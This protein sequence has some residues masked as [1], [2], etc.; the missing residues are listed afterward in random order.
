[1]RSILLWAGAIFVFGCLCACSSKSHT[2]D[3]Y[4]EGDFV[5]VSPYVSGQITQLNV[6]R[7]D[8]VT[9]GQPLFGLQS[10][11]ELAQLQAAQAAKANAEANLQ[12]LQKG[13]RPSEL[14]EIEGQIKQAQAQVIYTQQQEQRYKALIADGSIAQATLDQAIQDADNAR[15]MLKQYQSALKTAQLPAR[16]DLI[17]AAQMTVNQT[18]AQLAQAQW[19]YQQAMV[20]APVSGQVMDIY[21]WVGEQAV[22]MQ[23]VLVLLPPDKIKTVFFV[24][25]P[26]LKQIHLGES[27][28]VTC[29]GCKSSASAV[30]R[31]ISPTAEYTPPVIYSRSSESKLVYRVE[32]YFDNN[33]T[34][35]HPGQ[36]VMITASTEG[37]DE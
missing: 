31:F 27:V 4:V 35:W 12:N 19:T 9:L 16:K 30:I 13:D 10:T 1:M 8:T 11:T 29:D 28:S 32:A 17:H 18:T 5:Y 2:F 15:G 20:T 25:E 21:H 3:G 14:A 36:P 24:P 7:G 34:D 22:A 26:F 33:P 6:A 23:P 37:D